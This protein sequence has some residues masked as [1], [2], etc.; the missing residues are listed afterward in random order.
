MTLD[1]VYG[2]DNDE[3]PLEQEAALEQEAEEWDEETLGLDWDE[4]E[5]QDLAREISAGNN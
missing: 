5:A 4:T 1:D 2:P 3:F